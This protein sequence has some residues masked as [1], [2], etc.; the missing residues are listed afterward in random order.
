MSMYMSMYIHSL[1][2]GKNNGIMQTIW[3]WSPF[4]AT[5]R[6]LNV[7]TSQRSGCCRRW[8]RHK[9]P[10]NPVVVVAN[11]VQGWWIISKKNARVND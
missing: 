5:A 10:V 11:H 2:L 6:Q 8:C 4:W 9:G 3:S 1:P 7:A